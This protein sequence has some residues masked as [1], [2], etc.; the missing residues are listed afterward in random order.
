MVLQKRKK[1]A[2]IQFKLDDNK[3]NY[4]MTNIVPLYPMQFSP[5]TIF[6][7]DKINRY[8]KKSRQYIIDVHD[9]D[10]YKYTCPNSRITSKK[11]SNS[12]LRKFF[13]GN[14][15]TLYNINNFFKINKIDARL[16]SLKCNDTATTKLKFVRQS[17]GDIF[18]CTWNQIYHSNPNKII[19]IESLLEKRVA[20]NMNKENVSKIIIKKEKELGRPLL[21]SDFENCKT[22]MTSIGIRKIYS[23]WGSFSNMIKD[24]KLQEHDYFYKPNSIYY[25]PHEYYINYIKS[26][27]DIVKSEGRTVVMEKDFKLIDS[28]VR[29]VTVK[30]HCKLENTN[31]N[32][33][34][35]KYGCTLQQSGNGYNYIFE[36]GEHV[37]SRYEFDESAA[38]HS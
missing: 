18:T 12:N 19:N 28:S 13:R 5:S 14:Q 29:M 7:L 21:Q 11:D 35:K 4:F 3:L 37:Y 15:N 9:N 20:Y 33:M 1:V 24:L 38:A 32:E 31:L 30:N 26:I 36:D 23:I 2:Y 10:G 27:C 22:T 25:K 8:D 17:N 34:L 16:L 6:Y